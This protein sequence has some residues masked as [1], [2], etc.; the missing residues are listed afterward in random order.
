MTTILT[1]Q[2]QAI[3]SLWHRVNASLTAYD[4]LL[5]HFGSAES[6]INAGGQAW[7]EIGIHATHVARHKD[8]DKSQ[9]VLE[10][11]ERS[12]YQGEYQL[13]FA[14]DED[15]PKQLS[16][17]YDPPPLLFVKG[18]VARL[19]DAQ[20][21]V[22][23]SRKPTPHAQKITFDMAQYLAERGYVIT[24]G[25]AQ[26]VDKHAHL[27][28][29]EQNSP[30][31]LGRTVGVM[32]TGIDVCYP[33][34]H[35]PLFDRILATGGCLISEL[36]PS[37]PASKHTFPRRNRLVAGLSLAT[38]VT[39]AT[40]Q[41]G[42]LITARLTSEQGKQVFAVPSHIDNTNAQGCHHLIREGATLIYHP[43]Q[44]IEDVQ[45]QRPIISH[46]RQ[47]NAQA[48]H[49]PTA[50]AQ[51][52]DSNPPSLTPTQIADQT[53]IQSIPPV[54]NATPASEVTL[55]THLQAVYA[56]IDWNGIDLDNLA[57][58]LKKDAQTLLVQLM[59]LELMGLII[60]QGGH[61][62]RA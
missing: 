18:T 40:I 12:V 6:A 28:A 31:Q 45:T 55:P 43:E 41:S 51:Q 10:Q 47:L 49:Q 60:T 33:S 37:T 16:H 19:H 9:Q 15:Y 2:Q 35:A 44:V 1:D 7:T 59:E 36:L 42:S 38:I 26:G 32:G 62:L 39:E 24:S 46:I 11:V 23:G 54:S 4:R 14:D 58:K 50:H 53:A 30:E 21:A 13:V 29:L 56:Q 27:G 22:V 3:I 34:R 57:G 20:I 48:T 25:L 52:R 17:L 5:T 8:I 61:Y